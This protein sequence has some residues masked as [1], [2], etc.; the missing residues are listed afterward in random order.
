MHIGVASHMLLSP[1]DLIHQS[2]VLLLVGPVVDK[3]VCN[4][5]PYYS[6]VYSFLRELLITFSLGWDRFDV[7]Y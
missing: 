3:S 5:I 1:G 7:G 6:C 2:P 4:M